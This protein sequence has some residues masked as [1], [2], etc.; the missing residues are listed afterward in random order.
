MSPTAYSITLFFALNAL[1]LWANRR[2]RITKSCRER[3]MLD[4][5]RGDEPR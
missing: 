2:H 3:V 1:L 4:T 5:I